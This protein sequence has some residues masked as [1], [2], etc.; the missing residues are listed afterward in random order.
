MINYAIA[1]VSS[2]GGKILLRFKLIEEIYY[3]TFLSAVNLS[4]HSF[5]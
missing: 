4:E 5:I 3:S 1:Q 2:A